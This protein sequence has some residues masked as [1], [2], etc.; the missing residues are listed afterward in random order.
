VINHPLDSLSA[1]FSTVSPAA[2]EPGGNLNLRLRHT[3]R[4]LILD[5]SALLGDR[6]GALPAPCTYDL[7]ATVDNT[8][9]EKAPSRAALGAR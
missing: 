4:L 9:F 7:E 8:A 1:R 3:F 5:D 2:H 6:F